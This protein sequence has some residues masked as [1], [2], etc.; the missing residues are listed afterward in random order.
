MENTC[1]ATLGRIM[2]PEKIHVIIE[3]IEVTYQSSQVIGQVLQNNPIL[4]GVL[5]G[6][7]LGPYVK[8]IL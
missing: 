6:G 1:E 3:A 5:A 7:L 8:S 2:E 4:M